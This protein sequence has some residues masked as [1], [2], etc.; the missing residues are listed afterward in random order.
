MRDGVVENVPNQ[1]KGKE[2]YIPHKP[3][4]RENAESTKMRV[5]YDASKKEKECLPSTTVSI[6][7]HPYRIN[8]GVSEENLILFPSL[9]IC[10]RPFCK[11]E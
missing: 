6:H 8:F 10:R 2:F 4:I 7:D 1:T 3:V 11:S 9:G 5:V